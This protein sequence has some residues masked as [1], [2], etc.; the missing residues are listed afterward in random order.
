M[1]SVPLLR[2]H[3]TVSLV[4]RDRLQ[5][6]H[7][8][9]TVILVSSAINF[10]QGDGLDKFI[11]YVIALRCL[12][13][14]QNGILDILDDGNINLARNST[15]S[16]DNKAVQQGKKLRFPRDKS[17]GPVEITLTDVISRDPSTVGRST[18]VLGATSDQQ[19]DIELIVKASWPGSG[20]VSEIKFLEE[21]IER[22]ETTDGQWATKHLPRV[23]C[24]KDVDFGPDSTLELVAHLFKRGKIVRGEFEYERR[25]LR[26]IVQERLYP[27]KS[28]TNVKDVGQVFLDIACSTCSLFFPISM[29]LHWISPPL[30]PRRS[31]DPPPRP[32]F[33][34]RHVSSCQGVER[35]QRGK[36][37][38]SLRSINRLRPFFQAEGP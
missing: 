18:V 9:H 17:R 35:R 30:A 2:S 34:Q 32:Q 33:Q 12:T 13:P 5:L 20:R 38:Q 21:A 22:A 29:H 14:K 6:Y 16:A 1:F 11:A 27:L 36:R 4:D 8:N 26:I 19:K 37:A 24:S 10:S 25:T 31:W 7:A 3:A 15:I 23:I 28:L